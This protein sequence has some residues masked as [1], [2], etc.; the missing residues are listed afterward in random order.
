MQSSD[1]A[2]YAV[3]ITNVAGSSTS[4]AAILSVNLPGRLINLSVLTDIA[5]AGDDFTLGYVV[6][7]NST[8][9]TKTLVIRAGSICRTGT[10]ARPVFTLHSTCFRLWLSFS[11]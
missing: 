10:P 3:V 8:S 11:C 4:S 2:A 7:G 6:G 5:T 9:G 1:A